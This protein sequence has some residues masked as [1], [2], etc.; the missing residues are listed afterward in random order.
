MPGN[1]VLS[2]GN[3]WGNAVAART[4]GISVGQ[5]NALLFP[6]VHG[7][8]EG[9]ARDGYV[10]ARETPPGQGAGQRGFGRVAEPARRAEPGEM[11]NGLGEDMEAVVAGGGWR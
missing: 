9:H 11:V 3:L 4:C 1:A 2:V 6:A 7:V 5:A 8:H 10:A